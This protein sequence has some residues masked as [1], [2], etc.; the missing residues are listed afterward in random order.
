M[1]KLKESE[2]LSALSE[3]TRLRIAVLLSK[4]E[5]C[6]CELVEILKLP[7][8]SVSRH[9]ARLRSSG[10][11]EDRREGKWVHYGLS[12]DR[13]KFWDGLKELL[14]LL[15]DRVPFREDLQLLTE[16]ASQAP[17]CGDDSKFN[18]ASG[19]NVG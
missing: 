19:Q 1:A 16:R 7:Q 4:G 5:L 13:D 17:T 6:V 9:M 3:P 14:S 15:G 11:V 18:G 12:K 8:S 10:L 2:S